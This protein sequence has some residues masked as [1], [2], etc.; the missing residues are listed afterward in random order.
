MNKNHKTT[1]FCLNDFLFH[2]NVFTIEALYT[3]E[4]QSSDSKKYCLFYFFIR[5]TGMV[6]SALHSQ[7]NTATFLVLTFGLYIYMYIL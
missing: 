3:P 4:T 5:S 6:L 7:T 1:Q 2:T